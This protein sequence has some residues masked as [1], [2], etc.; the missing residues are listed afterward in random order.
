[1]SLNINQLAEQI[2]TLDHAEQEA[3]FKKVVELSF[4]HELVT[5]A[6]QYQERLAHTGKLDQRVEEVLAELDLIREE[7]AAHDYGA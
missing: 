7:I 6:R 1:M 2:A 3:L 5:L 4:Q